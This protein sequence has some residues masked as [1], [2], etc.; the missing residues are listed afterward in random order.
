MARE[1]CRDCSHEGSGGWGGG[2]ASN[3]GVLWGESQIE[4]EKEGLRPL[5]LHLGSAKEWKPVAPRQRSSSLLCFEK[6]S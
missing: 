2:G 6:M 4:R 3:L 5:L 1:G